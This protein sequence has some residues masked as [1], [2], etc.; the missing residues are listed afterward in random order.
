VN[1]PID[2][3]LVYPD[4]RSSNVFSNPGLP[5]GL[6]F[7]ARSLKTAGF[8][9]EVV[10]LNIDT[11]EYLMRRISET[12]PR[13]LGIS[14]LSY[15]CKESYELL[16]TVK[17]HRPQMKVIAGGPHITANREIALMECPA[18]DLGVFGE[19]D[20]SI[21][22]IVQGQ[23]VDSIKGLLH[24]EA[25]TV[26]FSEQREFI[27][28]LD[29]VPFPTYDGFKLTKYSKTMPLHSSRGCPY[30]CIFCGAPKILGKKWRGRSA[31]NM[32]E[33]VKYWYGK[34][35]RNFY[36]SDSNFAVD[37]AR[38]ASFCEGIVK[39][40][41]HACFV[42]DGLRADHVDRKLLDKMRHAGFTDLTFGV[43]SGSNRIL[44]N[45]RKDETREDIETA[46]AAATDLGFNVS[47]FFLIGSPGENETD[48]RQSFELATKYDVAR[49]YF[50]NLT[51]LPGTQVYDWA[52]EHGIVDGSERRYPEENFGFSK[53]ALF[54]TDVLTKDQISHHIRIA[55]RV[56][57]QVR[58]KYALTKGLAA[59][60]MKGFFSRKSTLDSI[61][62]FASNSI[63]APV[64]MG[65]WNLA[66]LIKKK[67][68][69]HI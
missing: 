63:I 59:T 49:V 25:G 32:I 23:P 38:V 31:K 58:F 10:D 55:R 16:N 57:R 44:Q 61:S 5:V 65:L 42:A 54:G 3:L 29:A 6:G 41:L 27:P 19:G 11:K 9:Y 56:E 22:E 21:L 48:I 7:I 35:Y 4:F 24:R 62:W 39:S 2:I 36:F 12:N 8:E 64:V 30:H 43:E 45:L 14:M 15:R 52:I 17:Y 60:K 34:G 26:R 69:P 20:I 66:A 68:T 18:I 28:N 53:R 46:I 33:E 1:D 47:L 37:K 50:F 67:R 13:F 40:E 51:P